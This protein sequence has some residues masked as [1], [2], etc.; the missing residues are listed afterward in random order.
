MSVA[1]AAANRIRR[2]DR[3]APDFC[4]QL[5]DRRIVGGQLA[6]LAFYLPGEFVDAQRQ[7]GVG[8]QSRAHANKGAHDQHAYFNSSGRTQEVR[9]HETAVLGE[10]DGWS[11][12][13]PLALPCTCKLQ[14][15]PLP[16]IRLQFECKVWR[17]PAHVALNLLIQPLGLHAI[18]ARQIRIQH[19]PLATDDEDG[20][21]DRFN[22]RQVFHIGEFPPAEAQCYADYLSEICG[23]AAGFKLG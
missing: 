14:V 19:H 5:E 2:D 13:A 6:A 22:G 9:R 8:R 1:R 17:K 4:Q 3:R 7:L 16:F 11:V 20:A 12:R 18:E 23:F 10:G 15:H 21:F